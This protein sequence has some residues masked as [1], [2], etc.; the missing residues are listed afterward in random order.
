MSQLSKVQVI[1]FN[2][3]RQVNPCAL[4]ASIKR[5]I[6]REE[7]ENLASLARI[8]LGD[9]EKKNL[10]KDVGA[11]LEYVSQIN[12]HTKN[13]IAKN[14]FAASTPPILDAPE[15]AALTNTPFSPQQNDAVFGVGVNVMREDGEP[16]ESGLYTEKLLS[17]A[18]QREG[19][20]IKV[21]KIL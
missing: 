4:C 3:L 21:K 12:P 5:M 18:P 17:A 7:I 8:E 15:K 11:I 1:F 19:Q 14:S 10:Q 20:Y 9:E 2:R 16:H 6:T 13:G